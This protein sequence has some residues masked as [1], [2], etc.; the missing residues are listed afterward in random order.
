MT[1]PYKR[2]LL[3]TH[4]QSRTR[5]RLTQSTTGCGASL[6]FTSEPTFTPTTSTTPF[7]I[8]PRRELSGLTCAVFPISRSDFFSARVLSRWTLGA[9]P[10]P[11]TSLRLKYQTRPIQTNN[12]MSYKTNNQTENL[13]AVPAGSPFTFSSACRFQPFV[14]LAQNFFHMMA[15]SCRFLKAF[16]LHRPASPVSCYFSLPKKKIQKKSACD[17]S[18]CCRA[19]VRVCARAALKLSVPLRLRCLLHSTGT[20]TPSRYIVDI[21]ALTSSNPLIHNTARVAAQRWRR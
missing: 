17:S 5:T 19:R 16:R 6:S 18:V 4:T 7:K 13:T 14:R 12:T 20:P 8:D 21:R 15:R 11:R 1:K 9:E 2:S 10:P 3:H